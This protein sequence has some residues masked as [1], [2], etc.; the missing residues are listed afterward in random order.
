MTA[1]ANGLD[2]GL[3]P[4]S[5]YILD[6]NQKGHQLTVSLLVAF[7]FGSEEGMG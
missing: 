7:A 1:T 3:K 5:L 6:V 2:G 4:T